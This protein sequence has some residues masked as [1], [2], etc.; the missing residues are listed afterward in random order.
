MLAVTSLMIATL[1]LSVYLRKAK[2]ISATVMMAFKVM[3]RHVR[4]SS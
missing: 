2:D 4:N 3:E 1:M